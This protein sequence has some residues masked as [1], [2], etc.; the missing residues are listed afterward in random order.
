[1]G[2]ID[3]KIKNPSEDLMIGGFTIIGAR[4]SQQDNAGG[5]VDSR[6][7][8]LTVC[9]GMGG[10]DD[11]GR[12]STMAVSM[13]EEAYAARPESQPIPVFFRSEILKINDRVSHLSGAGGRRLNTGTTVTAVVIDGGSLY[14]LSVGDSRIYLLR[15]N[16]LIQINR[17][18][19]Y[20]MRLQENLRQGM[21][22]EE[23]YLVEANSRKAEALISYVG[24]PVLQLMEINEQAFRLKKGDYVILCSDGLYKSLSDEQIKALV[25]DNDIDL[26]IAADRLCR[27]AH[28]YGGS[29]QDNTTLLIARYQPKDR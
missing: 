17:E 13:L 6:R 23:E 26:N 3:L 25:L 20:R 1:M 12:A 9:D 18:H 28:R 21:I 8:F 24:I 22:S 19:N 4:E 11:G 5:V 29:V 7:A 2:K 10:M 15:D 14:W 27:M 16:S